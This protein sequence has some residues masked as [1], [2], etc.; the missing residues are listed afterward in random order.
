MHFVQVLPFFLLVLS[1]LGDGQ[2]FHDETA[3]YQK[4]SIRLPPLEKLAL[5]NSSPKSHLLSLP[6]DLLK[7]EI[8]GRLYFR[9]LIRLS[10]SSKYFRQET[11]KKRVAWKDI[12]YSCSFNIFSILLGYFE[13]NWDD[14]PDLSNSNGSPP[15]MSVN[16]DPTEECVESWRPLCS[17]KNFQLPIPVHVRDVRALRPELMNL[18]PSCFEVQGA[19]FNRHS[20]YQIEHDDN[21]DDLMQRITPTDGPLSNS[22]R[23]RSLRILIAPS[24]FEFSSKQEDLFLDFLGNPRSSLKV[25]DLFYCIFSTEFARKWAQLLKLQL[26]PAEL[27]LTS[28]KDDQHTGFFPTLLNAFKINYSLKRLRIN[29]SR[30]SERSR[31]ALAQMMSENRGLE[32][33]ELIDCDLNDADALAL[34]EASLVHPRLN[35]LS[36]IYN[37]LSNEM[38]NRLKHMVS[39]ANSDIVFK[40]S[41]QN[42]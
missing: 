12:A 7:S 24:F 20:Q 15:I 37:P 10:R 27:R 2:T 6:S 30:L 5:E 32:Q 26:G 9:D 31:M 18:L 41:T 29:G 4:E 36:L 19:E 22:Q 42:P 33:L 34:V 14:F 21:W 38:V 25:L 17:L 23:I 11:A 35:V 28:F 3:G 40:V 16:E 39:D 1:E 13:R 8:I